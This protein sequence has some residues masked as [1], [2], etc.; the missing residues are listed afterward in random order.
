M[1]RKASNISPRTGKPK[2]PYVRKA[3]AATPGP[4]V[5]VDPVGESQ[6]KKVWASQLAMMPTEAERVE[7]S[8]QQQAAIDAL[9]CEKPPAKPAEDPWVHRSQGMK[10]RSC[11]WFLG[12]PSNGAP[13]PV[14]G[15]LGRCRRHAPTTNGFPAVFATDFC[16]DHKLDEN[17]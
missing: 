7:M 6:A 3:K 10:C 12:K 8:A 16:G 15:P 5:L 17:K 13:D 14:R 1:S 11:M 2:R 4:Y 9:M